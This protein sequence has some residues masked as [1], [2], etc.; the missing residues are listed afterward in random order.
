MQGIQRKVVYLSLYEG[1]AILC[2]SVG[3]SWMSGEQLSHSGM[4]AVLMSTVA[5]A[6]NFVYT[7]AFEHWESRQATSGR[8]L[9]RRIVHAIGFEGGLIAVLVPVVAWWMDVSLWQALVMDLALA[10]YFLVYAFAFNWAFDRLFG[11]PTSALGR[12]VRTA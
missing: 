11:L 5:L 6:W 4:L 12:Q 10:T 7:L 9:R 8:S 3:L 1:L 2:S